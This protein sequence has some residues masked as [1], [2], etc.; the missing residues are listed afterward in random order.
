MHGWKVSFVP[1]STFKKVSTFEYIH[2]TSHHTL[3]PTC[4]SSCHIE[5]IIHRPHTPSP[6]LIW[7]AANMMA[8]H[9]TAP[10]HRSSFWWTVAS[11]H[12]TATQGLNQLHH[13][14][15]V[16]RSSYLVAFEADWIG[17]G[18]A[19]V[20]LALCQFKWGSLV[21][22]ACVPCSAW[23][24]PHHCPSWG[25]EL[26]RWSSSMTDRRFTVIL[27]LY[28]FDFCICHRWE[29]GWE[30]FYVRLFMYLL[31]LYCSRLWM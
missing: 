11:P 15:S 30:R 26:D 14:T 5:F 10:L 2:S 7:A 31:K 3:T 12:M 9:F 20:I 24:S 6:Y 13:V 8:D 4:S 27:W 29:L 18:R 21:V 19:F 22:V 28:L 16:S 17:W 23:H 1:S 25:A